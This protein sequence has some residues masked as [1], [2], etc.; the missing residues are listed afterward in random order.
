MSI[1]S[2]LRVLAVWLS[3]ARFGPVQALIAAAIGIFLPSIYGSRFARDETYVIAALLTG[4]P[5][6]LALLIY[7][8]TPTHFRPLGS[9]P[10]GWIVGG[11][12]VVLAIAGYVIARSGVKDLR[13]SRAGLGAFKVMLALA[14]CTLPNPILVLLGPATLVLVAPRGF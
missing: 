14:F 2:S 9:S 12:F 7:L 4:G 13:R 5:A 11:L 1:S 3:F 8:V 6:A 10:T